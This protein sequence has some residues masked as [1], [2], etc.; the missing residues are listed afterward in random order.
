MLSAP[1]DH[2]PSCQGCAGSGWQTGPTH[3]ITNRNGQTVRRYNTVVPCTHHWTDDD[4]TPAD[5]IGRDEYLAQL[6]P[7]HP[8]HRR[9]QDIEQRWS[10]LP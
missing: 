9:W 4:P 5:P 7:D 2:P 10:L 8:D 3:H 6:D 1:T